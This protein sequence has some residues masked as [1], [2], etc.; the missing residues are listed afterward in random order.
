MSLW[1]FPFEP[2]PNADMALLAC[3]KGDSVMSGVTQA[4][5]RQNAIEWFCGGVP[6]RLNGAVSK[7]AVRLVRT[8]G[9]NPSPSAMILVSTAPEAP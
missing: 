1:P 8:G 5:T 2:T 9:S 3:A 7:T 4:K 6:E